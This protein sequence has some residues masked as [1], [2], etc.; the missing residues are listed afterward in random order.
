MTNRTYCLPGWAWP[1]SELAWEQ[2]FA[3]LESYVVEHGDALVPRGFKT[4]DRF[5]LGAWLAYQRQQKDSMLVER[6]ERLEALGG[7]MWDPDD[8]NWESGF[9]ALTNF[10][11]DYG[12][13]SVPRGFKTANGFNLG[14]WVTAQRRQKDSMP[15]TRKSRLEALEGWVWR[16]DE[17]QWQRGFAALQSYIHKHGDARVPVGFMAPNGF[18]LGIWVSTQRGRKESMPADRKERLEALKGWIWSVK[19]D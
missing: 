15:E 14:W 4:A 10:V 3:A 8:F 19:N 5:N 9:A 7:W 17:L 1:T 2:G 11:H 6:K 13:A 12:E 18:T 16:A